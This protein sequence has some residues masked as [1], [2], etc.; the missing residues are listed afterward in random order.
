MPPMF[1]PDG[2]WWLPE[3]VEDAGKVLYSEDWL[4]LE[5]TARPL[6]PLPANEDDAQLLLERAGRVERQAPPTGV[7][8]DSGIILHAIPR[9]RYE[10]ESAAFFRFWDASDWLSQRLFAQ[11]VSADVLDGR[12][13]PIPAWI[14]SEEQFWTSAL[15][16]RT[17]TAKVRIGAALEGTPMYRNGPILVKASEIQEAAAGYAK[18]RRQNTPEQ[19]APSANQGAE[20]LPK[21]HSS[22]RPRKYD[23][24]AFYREVIRIANLPDGLPATQAELDRTMAEWF[25]RTYGQEP[26]ESVLKERV[27]NIYRHLKEGG[28]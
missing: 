2:Y 20:D 25:Q 4:G 28:N 16:P 12:L 11:D 7:N 15:R 13:W 26:S 19:S 9:D 1:V 27:R 23:W 22:G 10:R 6:P 8:S 14:W 5:P 21:G 18:K 17:A 24:D 3:A